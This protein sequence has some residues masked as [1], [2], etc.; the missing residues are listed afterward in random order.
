M[1]VKNTLTSL[2]LVTVLLAGGTCYAEN[3]E[4]PIVARTEYKLNFATERRNAVAYKSVRHQILHDKYQQDLNKLKQQ[5]EQ[6]K[7][8]LES[9]P[10]PV[11]TNEPPKKYSANGVMIEVPITLPTDSSKEIYDLQ[12]TK[13]VLIYKANN[14]LY[15]GIFMLTCEDPMTTYRAVIPAS[16]QE[17]NPNLPDMWY[18]INNVEYPESW[19]AF[20][21]DKTTGV[22]SF[23]TDYENKIINYANYWFIDINH[24]ESRRTDKSMPIGVDAVFKRLSG[25]DYWTNQ[26]FIS[27]T[28]SDGMLCFLHYVKK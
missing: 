3:K 10:A 6:L 17:Q 12:K 7:A 19:Y 11:A 27:P 1:K 28:I 21:Y 16:A 13:E 20:T 25:G 14:E 22:F 5:Y 8:E 9:N 26:T 4:N 23:Y 18:K 24:L 15:E 2:G